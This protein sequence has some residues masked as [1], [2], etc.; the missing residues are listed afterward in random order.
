MTSPTHIFF[1]QF[2]LAFATIGQGI[3]LNTANA[4]ACSLGSLA[5]DIDNSNSWL[6]RLLPFLSKPIERKF[7]HRTLFHSIFAILSLVSIAVAIKTLDLLNH[8]TFQLFASFSIGYT[9]HILL[10][11]TS[12]QGVKI[13]YPLSMKNAVFPFDTQ[14]PESYRI[15]VGS[16]AD[17]VLGFIFLILAFPL[18]Y[19]SIQSHKKIHTPNPKRH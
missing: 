5:P 13:L 6:G 9:S 4:L 18:A 8:Q 3:E 17:I 1:A 7:G 15:K 11:C 12:I 2:C 14:Q 10:D 16:K 19:I